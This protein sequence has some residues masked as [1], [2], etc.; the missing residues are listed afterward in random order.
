VRILFM[1]NYMFKLV[2]KISNF[3]VVPRRFDTTQDVQYSVIGSVNSSG[4]S[5]INL[6]AQFTKSLNT[7]PPLPY[8]YMVVR[9]FGFC[10]SCLNSF[11][12]AL[13]SLFR[14]E[15]SG[16]RW[17]AFLAALSPQSDGGRIFRSFYYSH[18]LIIRERSRLNQLRERS[19][20]IDV[21]R[22]IKAPATAG[23]DKQNVD[24]MMASR[25]V[26]SGRALRQPVFPGC[27]ETCRA[28][29]S[30]RSN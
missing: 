17:T 29:E 2:R 13:T 20:I 7:H 18:N 12:C 22:K 27:S 14:C 6:F 26:P 25:S 21:S 9:F 28:S 19:G 1:K 24:P 16:P 11:S 10:P 4:L 15:F 23:T 30:S 5:L 8:Y 3:S